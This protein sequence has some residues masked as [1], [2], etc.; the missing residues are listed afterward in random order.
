MPIIW[1][2]YQ[3]CPVC[4]AELGKPCFSVTGMAPGGTA[5][6]QFADRPHSGRQLRAA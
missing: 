2:R 4:S 5:V 1:E 6:I 3:K